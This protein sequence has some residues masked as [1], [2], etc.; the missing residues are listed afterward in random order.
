VLVLPDLV[1]LTDRFTPRYL[2]RYAEMAEE[3]RAAVRR[4]GDEVRAGEFPSED[5]GF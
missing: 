4:F 1:G 3:V 2:K 5:H